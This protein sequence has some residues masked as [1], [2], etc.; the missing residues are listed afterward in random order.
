MNKVE[1]VGKRQR[2]RIIEQVLGLVSNF[3]LLERGMYVESGECIGKI[4]LEMIFR[5][6]MWGFK[7][8]FLQGMGSYNIKGYKIDRWN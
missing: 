2:G 1:N 3:V 6:R 5:V 7:F 4:I 8:K